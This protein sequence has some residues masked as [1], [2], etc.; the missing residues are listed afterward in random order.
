VNRIARFIWPLAAALALLPWVGSA[1]ALLGGAVLA[2]LFGNPYQP[3]FKKWTHRLLAWSVIGLGAGM[4]LRVVLQ[5]GLHG[6]GYTVVSISFTLALGMWLARRMGVTGNTG[7]LVSVGTAICGG[8][9]IAAVSPVINAEEHETSVA[10]GTVFLLNAA[11]LV[12]FP[13]IGRAFHLS[14]EG[15]G[16]WAAL[17][18]HDTSSVV[19]AALSY[20]QKAL[21]IAVTVKLAR[22]LWIVPVAFGIGLLRREKGEAKGKRPWFILGFLATAALATY[23]P[24]LHVPAQWIARG[25]K[26]GLVLT[27]FLIG[28]GLTPATLRKVGVRPFL[29]GLLLWVIVA[30]L[31]LVA[32]LTG[33]LR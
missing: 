14:Q 24:I 26:Q 1:T 11:A 23:V 20:G 2:I 7:L 12:I 25:A 13:L 10:L 9:A 17:A 32:V 31:S 3:L 18:I 15:F 27:L 29:H 21:Q 4:D 16:L 5:A 33:W 19:G 8:S 30:S 22:A 6:L 28:A